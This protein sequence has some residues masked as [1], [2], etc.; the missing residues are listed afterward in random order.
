[1][2]LSRNADQRDGFLSAHHSSDLRLGHSASPGSSMLEHFKSALRDW[3]L[4]TGKWG[5]KWEWGGRGGGEASEVLSIQQGDTKRFGVV[6][7]HVLEV[8]AIL[9]GR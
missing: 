8:L 4:I 1:M 2:R 7:T 3:Q 9:K 6:T 5:S